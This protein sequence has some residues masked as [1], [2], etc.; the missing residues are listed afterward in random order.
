[1]GRDRLGKKDMKKDDQEGTGRTQ[2]KGGSPLALEGTKLELSK[3]RT[4][5]EGL[6]K[7]LV[8][9]SDKAKESLL[10]ESNLTD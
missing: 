2:F 4:L 1:L 6:H 7:K 9:Q 5:L 10:D 3:N 8:F